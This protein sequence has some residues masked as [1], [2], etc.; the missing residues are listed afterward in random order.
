MFT[1]KE[2]SDLGK[3][4]QPANVNDRLLTLKPGL[5]KETHNIRILLEWLQHNFP[6]A[7]PELIEARIKNVIN[8]TQDM[9]SLASDAASLQ[10][11]IRYHFPVATESALN[12]TFRKYLEQIN[13]GFNDAFV[14]PAFRRINEEVLKEHLGTGIVQETSILASNR[15][16]ARVDPRG[17]AQ[18]AIG[19]E[20]N[21]L[22]AARQ[23]TNIFG[24]FGKGSATSA[25]SSP[26]ALAQ[27]AAAATPGGAAL[28][29][30]QSIINGLDQQRRYTPAVYGIST[31]NMFEVTPIVD[32]SGQALRFR[33]DF[34]L[35][36]Q[37][38]EP[39]DTIDP[40]LPRI[41]RHSVNT[42]VHL[43]NQEIRLIS[44]FQ[45]NSRLGLP[46]R[47]WGGIPIL[48]DIPYVN[49]VPLIGWFVR[50]S[51]QAAVTQQSLI[52]CQTMMYPTL[53]EVLDLFAETPT[54]RTEN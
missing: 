36:T 20:Q 4:P 26:T 33:F 52:F 5:A 19:E 7:D 27:T 48:N 14:K 12:L 29:A 37:I 24:S 25:V 23:L 46:E 35:G 22:E 53:S 13:Q 44:E 17:T 50:H 39:N 18:L 49:E 43:A 3:E 2:I 31:G 34:L 41:E 45:S 11:A 1:E 38:R 16:G 9:T 15:L 21:I 8:G 10:S 40:Q 30:V 47:K 42:E 32:P 54:F 28:S 6:G 51:G